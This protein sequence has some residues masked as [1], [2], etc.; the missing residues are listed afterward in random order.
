MRKLTLMALLAALGGCDGPPAHEA[1]DAQTSGQ[2]AVEADDPGQK[3]AHA[4]GQGLI[5]QPAPV[6]SLTTIDGKTI[7]L[8]ALYGKKP[9]Y[10]K[11][12]ATWCV[13]CR[14]QMPHFT[15]TY[16]T[17]EEDFAVIAVNTGFNETNEAIEAYTREHGLHMPV[18]I[19]DGR[20]ADAFNLRVTPQHVVIGRDGRIQYVGHLA[21]ARLEQALQRAASQPAGRQRS[22]QPEIIAQVRRVGDTVPP[23]PIKTVDGVRSTIGGANNGQPTAL[24]F[25][26]PWCESY[27]A[28]SRPAVSQACRRVRERVDMLAGRGGVRWLGI[29]SRL[30]ATEEDVRDYGR[31]YRVAMPLV[32]DDSGTLFRAFAVTQVPTVIFLDGKGRIVSRLEANDADIEDALKTAQKGAA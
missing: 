25:L 20:L 13:P 4:A 2:A 32:Y 18:V 10:L 11:F 3:H 1:A 7:D 19:D 24:V 6:M 23:V 29:A 15:Q 27:L 9:V 22:D 30:W 26:S 28:E 17:L 8:G 5:G 31:E 21:D 14:E 12:W 16:A